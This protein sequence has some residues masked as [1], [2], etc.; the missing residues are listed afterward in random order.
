[1][2]YAVIGGYEAVHKKDSQ[3]VATEGDWIVDFDRDL[4]L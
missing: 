1:M 3:N 2:V 4:N